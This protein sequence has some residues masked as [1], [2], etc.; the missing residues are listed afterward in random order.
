MTLV[1]TNIFECHRKCCHQA[2][3]TDLDQIVRKRLENSVEDCVFANGQRIMFEGGL[4]Y[5]KFEIEKLQDFF[6][7]LKK[8]KAPQD[9]R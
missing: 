3:L 1:L 7:Y 9:K 8:V 4:Q 5:T 2:R 6:M